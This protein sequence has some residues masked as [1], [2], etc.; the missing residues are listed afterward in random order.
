MPMPIDVTVTTADN[1]KM[2][3]NIPL[4]SMFGIKKSDAGRTFDYKEEWPWTNPTYELTIPLNID[5]L[6]MIEIDDSQ[7]MADIFRDNN[8]WQSE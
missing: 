1:K 2:H 5:S 3:Y 6:K 8:V 4:K 7:R